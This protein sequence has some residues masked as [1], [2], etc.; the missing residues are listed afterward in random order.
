MIPQEK[1]YEENRGSDLRRSGT[2]NH[3]VVNEMWDLH[4]EI[5]RRLMLGQKNVEIAKALGCTPQ[6]VSN[7]KNSPVVQEHI[8]IMRG[9]RDADTVDLSKEIMEIAPVALELLKDIIKGEGD[10][11]NAGIGLRAKESNNMMARVGHGVP[12]KIQ[13]ESTNL[14]LTTEDIKEIRRRAIAGGD[15]IDVEASPCEPETFPSSPSSNG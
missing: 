10:G 6:T 9:A 15:V 14:F 7:V 12:H 13:A 2:R 1:Y 8:T 5:A 4:H 11:A 3:W